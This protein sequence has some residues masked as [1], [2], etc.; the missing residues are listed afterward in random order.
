MPLDW[1]KPGGRTIRLALIH[2]LASKPRG[3]DRLTV[4]QP[5]RPRRLRRCR[6]QGGRQ[7]AGPARSGP[8]RHR[9][10]GSPRF[11]YERGRGLLQGREAPGE[12]L[13]S[14][15]DPDHEAGPRR[16]LPKTVAFAERCGAL[17]GGLLAHIS[18][19]DTVRDLDYLRRLVG[20]RETHLLRGV[21]RHVPGPD[22]RQHVPAPGARNG[23]RRVVDPVAWTAGTE[24]SIANLRGDT[25]RV[26]EKFQ[27]LC[28]SAGPADCALAGHRP[29]ARRVGRLLAALRRRPIAAPSATPAG[30][31]AYGEALTAITLGLDAPAGWPRLAEDLDAAARGDGS[32]LATRA[33]EGLMDLYSVESDQT[34][35]IVCADSPA[36]Q[37]PRA[38]PR[39]V[40][41]LTDVSAIG[42][43]PYAWWLWAACA[44]WPVRGADRYEGPWDATTNNPILVLGPRFDPS[45]PFGNARRVARRLGNAVLLAQDG[46]GH[47]SSADPSACVGDVVGRYLVDLVTPP[48]GTVCPSDRLP[49]DPD[50]GEPIP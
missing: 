41:R 6:R 15:T 3:A 5:G 25:D 31:L 35:A 20:D 37:G 7:S 1:D 21:R 14:A 22:L 16:Y 8:V 39:V 19:T 32:S 2:H 44:S 43:P 28:E 12:V 23:P 49:F 13:G 34:R 4:H 42:G 47:L 9:Q 45:T 36:R 38:W 50:F 11:W 29:V 27:S 46:Y 10:L 18:T 33:R 40:D 24:A 48:R 30:S 26:F 17:N